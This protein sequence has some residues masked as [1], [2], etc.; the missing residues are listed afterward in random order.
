M[1]KM[2][3]WNEG[4][5]NQSASHKYFVL[6]VLTR[7]YLQSTKSNLCESLVTCSHLPVMKKLGKKKKFHALSILDHHINWFW[8]MQVFY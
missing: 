4:N 5:S 1:K 6:H 3:Q 7:V 8:F 2:V